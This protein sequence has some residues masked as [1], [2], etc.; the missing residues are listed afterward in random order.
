MDH[1]DWRPDNPEPPRFAPR[2][3]DMERADK[4]TAW[5]RAYAERKAAQDDPGDADDADD[6]GNAPQ[7]AYGPAAVPLTDAARAELLRCAEAYEHEA[8]RL[9]K[10]V[11]D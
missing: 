5:Q 8:A 11:G 9:R 6:L 10:F 1:T 3:N 4:P 2:A 7:P